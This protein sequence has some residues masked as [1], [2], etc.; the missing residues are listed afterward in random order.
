MSSLCASA[1]ALLSCKRQSRTLVKLPGPCHLLVRASRCVVRPSY[2]RTTRIVELFKSP[3]ASSV[4]PIRPHPRSCK[5]CMPYRLCQTALTGI[6]RSGEQD[7]AIHLRSCS[8]YDPGPIM[9]RSGICRRHVGPLPCAPPLSAHRVITWYASRVGSSLIQGSQAPRK[10]PT[11][12]RSLIDRQPGK[13]GCSMR[14]SKSRGA[15]GIS[16]TLA[17]PRCWPAVADGAAIA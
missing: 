3:S 2:R 10:C 16:Q 14:G 1:S 4:S 11:M 5:D 6:E 7:D 13:R 12:L 15:N 9:G 8:W 17:G